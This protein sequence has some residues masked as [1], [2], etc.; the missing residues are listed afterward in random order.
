MSTSRHF[1][2]VDD[3]AAREFIASH[4]FKQYDR[5]R[6]TSPDIR[7]D[8]CL[9]TVMTPASNTGFTYSIRLDGTG[10]IVVA[11]IDQMTSL[12]SQPMPLARE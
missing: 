4:G 2:F 5:V 8:R 12:D 6:I 11:G 10:E 3:T 1:R 9:G 7:Y